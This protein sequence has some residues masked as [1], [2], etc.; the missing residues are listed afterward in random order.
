M[1]EQVNSGTVKV[2][3]R[4]RKSYNFTLDNTLWKKRKTNLSPST[5][6]V[7]VT[8]SSKP[9]VRP[10]HSLHQGIS[11]NGGERNLA[12][13]MLLRPAV[14]SPER[15]C[16]DEVNF[17]EN[18]I[19]SLE[20]TNN[21]Y[22]IFLDN[23]D[24]EV[25]KKPKI[26]LIIS[27]QSNLGTC[28]S[29]K[30]LHCGFETDRTP[31]YDRGSN[32]KCLLNSALALP[33]IKTKIGPSDIQFLLACLNVK[34][35]SL[36]TLNQVLSDASDI[37]T[38]ENKKSMVENQEYVHQVQELKGQGNQV[39]I[40]LDTSYNNRMQS[41]ME[42]GTMS[43]SPAVECCTSR[44]LVVALNIC[45]KAC[46]RRG[47]CDHQ[48]C[49]KNYPTDKSIASSEAYSTQKN[50]KAIKNQNI[51]STRSVTSDQSGQVQKVVREF[52][53]SISHYHC[54][55]HKLRN[56]QKKI[57][58]LKLKSL[59]EGLDS[60]TFCRHVARAMRSRIYFEITQWKKSIPTQSQFLHKIRQAIL[61][62][63]PCFNGN[64]DLCSSVSV[65]CRASTVEQ[66]INNLPKCQYLKLTPSDE[67]KL[68]TELIR[69][70]DLT[71]L[72]KLESLTNTNKVES[73]HHRCFTVAPKNTHWPKNFEGLCHSAVHSDSKKT[74]KSSS[75]LARRLG[76]VYGP[77]NPFGV[78]MSRIDR[79]SE[80][81]KKKQSR[82]VYKQKRFHS[83]LRR[84]YRKVYAK[85]V[86]STKC[87]VS[88]S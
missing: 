43:I 72:K 34:P 49:S 21:L 8:C 53:P 77:K 73:I 59:M 38:E 54:L 17:Q 5:S 84:T 78:H 55:V 35:P 79:L 87:S 71:S 50:L 80:Y 24:F 27:K 68:T 29:C 19:V 76:I 64:H 60:E 48:N 74:G 40:Q 1:S 82:K 18:H 70:A 11:F 13:P 45:N 7:E 23:H 47:K 15:Q 69:F 66:V 58:N 85:S 39:D 42:A 2:R 28:A 20:K 41:G 75:L 32:N 30:C 83:R 81:Y 16:T 52:S 14:P 44:K 62:I 9:I 46:T 51:L 56:L 88:H 61:N 12:A 37:A 10:S 3:G 36:K 57:Q 33:M 6:E 63:I 22:Q 31:L 26:K 25:C 4:K 86:Y 65:F 67:E